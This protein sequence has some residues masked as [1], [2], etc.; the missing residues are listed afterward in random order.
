MEKNIF[1]TKKVWK[2]LFSSPKK[3]GYFS[4]KSF[5]ITKKVYEISFLNQKNMAITKKIKKANCFLASANVHFSNFIIL[6]GIKGKKNDAI[7]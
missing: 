7:K 5:L 2:K 6:K 4:K 3:C 1:F